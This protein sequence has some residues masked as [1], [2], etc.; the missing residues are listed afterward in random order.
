MELLTVGLGVRLQW[1]LL[2]VAFMVLELRGILSRCCGTPRGGS[3]RASHPRILPPPVFLTLSLHCTQVGEEDRRVFSE[4]FAVTNGV[5]P[6]CVPAPTLFSLLFFAMLIDAYRDKSPGVRIAY[7][8]DGQLLN[9]RWMHS[10]SRVSTATI[11]DRLIAEDYALNA[12]TKEDM[13]RSMH[14]F[15]AACGNFG[16]RINMAETMVMHQPPPNTS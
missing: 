1:L 15:A 3:G 6:G 10:Q 4:A 12:A 14:L 13:Q 9:Q 2:N 11:H 7:R 16:L 5:K 8:M